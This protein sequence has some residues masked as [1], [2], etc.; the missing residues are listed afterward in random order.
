MQLW[1]QH[2]LVN[3]VKPL[4]C[5]KDRRNRLPA[6]YL[7]AYPDEIIDAYSRERCHG[8]SRQSLNLPELQLP[9]HILVRRAGVFSP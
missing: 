3:A 2:F 5:L 7:F 9:V 1:L 6:R 8:L 4:V